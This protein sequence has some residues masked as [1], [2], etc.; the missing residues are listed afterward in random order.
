MLCLP[1][2]TEENVYSLWEELRGR[3]WVTKHCDCI[4]FQVGMN[5]TCWKSWTNLTQMSLMT[6]SIQVEDM[7]TVP[8]DRRIQLL[9]H[10]ETWSFDLNIDHPQMALVSG[11]WWSNSKE[12]NMTCESKDT[13]V[14]PMYLVMAFWIPVVG[15][16]KGCKNI[17]PYKI[18]MKP[19]TIHPLAC[20][21]SKVVDEVIEQL[22]VLGKK[23]L[24]ELQTILGHKRKS[25]IF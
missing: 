18:A 3:G 22:T 24:L 5:E 9:H 20:V 4:M 12:P 2:I 19:P 15:N 23:E 7:K 6:A 13:V 21:C 16:W 17:F 25:M 14:H 8:W 10:T 11:K 1:C